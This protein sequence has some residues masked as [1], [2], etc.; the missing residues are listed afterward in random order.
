MQE[1]LLHALPHAAS[2]REVGDPRRPHHNAERNEVNGG[3]QKSCVSIHAL[4]HRIADEARIGTDRSILED[5]LFSLRQTPIGDRRKEHTDR[6]HQHGGKER[7]GHLH[8]QLPA[9]GNAECLDDIAG[10]NEVQNQIGEAL[11]ACIGDEFPPAKQ[12]S[13]RHRE[14]HHAHLAENLA[15]QIAL[16]PL[17]VH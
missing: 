6:L 13:C 7:H 3:D 14:R 5:L 8:Q 15:V 9:E 16:S 17:S 12:I 11:F 1:H 2:L 10:E 4:R